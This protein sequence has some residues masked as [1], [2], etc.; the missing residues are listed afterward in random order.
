MGSLSK[1]RVIFFVFFFLTIIPVSAFS[2]QVVIHNNE[3]WA[4]VEVEVRTGYSSDCNSNQDYQRVSIQKEGSR[5]LN[6]PDGKNVCYR[7]RVDPDNNSSDWSTW[8]RVPASSGTYD[9]NI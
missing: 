4:N 9:V 3:P 1:L 6:V 7:R 8:K 5:T 2:A